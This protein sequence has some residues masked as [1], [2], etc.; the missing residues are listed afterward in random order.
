MEEKE[1]AQT[2]EEVPM[3][4]Y[5]FFEKVHNDTIQ[6]VM[7]FLDPYSFARLS[8]VSKAFYELGQS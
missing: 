6:K 7:F 5:N 3:L 2:K 1:E 4:G 8:F